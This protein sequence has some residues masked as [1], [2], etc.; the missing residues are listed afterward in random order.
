MLLLLSSLDINSFNSI[1]SK[2]DKPIV[3]EICMPNILCSDISNGDF[4]SEMVLDN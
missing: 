4:H 2:F 3:S 1:L